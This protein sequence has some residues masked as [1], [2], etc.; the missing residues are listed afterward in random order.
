M[1]E[2]DGD[3]V[4]HFGQAIKRHKLG[5]LDPRVAPRIEAKSLLE[6]TCPDAIKLT[7]VLRG[8][9]TGHSGLACLVERL[10]L[11]MGSHRSDADEVPV[12][13]AVHSADPN[14]FGIDAPAR[15]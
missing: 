10:S 15:T 11:S 1:Q 6:D 7:P 2:V 12:Q 5:V 13:L 3:R 14:V 8:W 9:P 4:S